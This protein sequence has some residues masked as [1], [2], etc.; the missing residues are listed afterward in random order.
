MTSEIWKLFAS[1]GVPG[2]ALGVLY[3]LFRRF[4][5]SFP[6]VPQAYVG[7]IVI[8]F[9][10]LVTGIVFYALKL[11]APEI[12]N[13][14]SNYSYTDSDA[15][16]LPYFMTRL[17]TEDDLKGKSDWQLDIIRNEIFA[18]HGRRFNRSDLQ[19]YFYKQEWYVPKFTPD[20][21]P[22][23]L[24][25]ELQQRNAAFILNYQQKP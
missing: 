10:L 12:R 19:N 8:L 9:M 18:R 3:F 15:T 25:T 14:G 11:W 1:L 2:V 5:W 22:H 6:R 13:N 4:K 24:L 17:V 16:E 21:F 7:P 23:L 20:D